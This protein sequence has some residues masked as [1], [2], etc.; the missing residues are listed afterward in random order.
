MYSIAA[1]SPSSAAEKKEAETIYRDIL[2]NEPDNVD[3]LR[4]LAGLATSQ[5]EHRDAEILLKRAIELTPDFGRALADLVVNQ[6][7]QEKIDEALDY[8][9]RL[10]QIGADNPDSYLLTGNAFSVAGRY[11]DAINAYNK[12]LELAPEHPGALSGLAHNLKTVGKQDEAIAIYRKCIAANPYFTETYWS[13]ANLKTFRFTDKEVQSMEK[14]LE[15][16][17]IPGDAQVHL[18]NALGF[19]YENQ[20][21][22]DRAFAYFERCNVAKRQLEYYDPVET[23]FLYDRIIEVFDQE[24]VNRAPAGKE[25]DVTPIFIIGLPRS[26]STL[27]EQIL[28]S[29]SRVEGT[30]ELSDLARVVKEIPDRL[31][32]RQHY[33]DALS[34]A[35]AALLAELGQAY[36]DRTQ[37]YRSGHPF[38]TDKNPNNFIHVGLAHLALPD[39]VFINA[40][41]HPFDSC[42]GSF[43]QLFAKGQAFSYDL[44][45]IGE[46]YLQYERLMEHWSQILPGKVLDVRYEDVV[47]NVDEQVTRILDHCGLPFEEQCVHFHETERAIKTASSEQVRKP[48]YSSSVNLWRNYEGHLG[49][50]IEILEP[51]LRKLPEEDRPRSMTGS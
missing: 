3:A 30:H 11:E 33:P 1:V 10:T 34:G 24:F 48:I 14:L 6:V 44:V 9:A 29:H 4:L 28:A 43:K 18:C 36:L 2:K 27:L 19:Q 22:Y 20:K 26:G 50:V 51:L 21:A 8:A 13:L 5:N 35:D 23:E 15:H 31:K 16:P 7:E 42:L 45:D 25:F 41:R 32:T 49:P 17:N 39:A 47:A 12:A 40:R 38:F 37:K 46:Y